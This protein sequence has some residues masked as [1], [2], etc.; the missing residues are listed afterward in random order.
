MKRRAFTLIELLTVIAVIGILAGIAIPSLGKARASAQGAQCSN[1]LKSIA[2]ET[3]RLVS[4]YEGYLP[5]ANASFAYQPTRSGGHYNVKFPSGDILAQIDYPALHSFVPLGDLTS[6]GNCPVDPESGD[7]WRCPST[8]RQIQAIGKEQGSG[9]DSIAK[10]I[11]IAF[12]P[13]NY[14]TKPGGRGQYTYDLFNRT[15]AASSTNPPRGLRVKYNS[16]D[17]PLAY[18]Q[19]PMIWESC[20]GSVSHHSTQAGYAPIEDPHGGGFNVSY[21]DSHVE[22]CRPGRGMYLNW[23]PGQRPDDKYVTASGDNSEK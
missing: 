14:Q 19:V 20:R 4:V 5:K 23:A 21:L 9:S 3:I 7:I 12:N 11:G 16:F 6:E 18:D 22:V 2:T 8:Y 17:L 13:S 10:R 15:Y 1:N